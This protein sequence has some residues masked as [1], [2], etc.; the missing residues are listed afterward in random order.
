MSVEDIATKLEFS[1]TSI[2][3]ATGIDENRLITIEASLIQKYGEEFT[4][5]TFVE[6]GIIARKRISSQKLEEQKQ[7]AA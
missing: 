5:N 2:S 7:K 6:A 1:I 3:K 4:I